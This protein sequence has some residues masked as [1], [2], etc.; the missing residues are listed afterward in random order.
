MSGPAQFDASAGCRPPMSGIGGWLAA[1]APGFFH[2]V[3]V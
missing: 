3:S 1:G 2:A